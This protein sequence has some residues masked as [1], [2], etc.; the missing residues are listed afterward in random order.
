MSTFP[1][2]VEVFETSEFLSV[3]D[4]YLTYNELGAL[5]YYLVCNLEAGK[6]IRQYPGLR[7]LEFGN[8]PRYRVVYLVIPNKNMVAMV[9]LLLPNEHLPDVESEDGI[10]SISVLRSLVKVGLAVALRE[11]WGWIYKLLD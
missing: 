3:A 1:A 6:P 11:A 9:D 2:D 5:K 4:D 7:V 8:D 10:N